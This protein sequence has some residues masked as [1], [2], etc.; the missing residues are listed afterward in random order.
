MNEIP[1]HQILLVTDLIEPRLPATPGKW[2]LIFSSPNPL[3]YKEIMKYK[4]RYRYTLPTWS[5]EEMHMVDPDEKNWLPLYEKCGGIIRL[6]LTDEADSIDDIEDALFHKGS[7]I[8]NYF[9]KYGFGDL[10]IET[11]SALIHM[12]PPYSV[13]KGGFLYRAPP[14]YSFASDYVFTQLA[15]N[16]DTALMAEVTGWFDAGGGKASTKLGGATAEYLFKKICLYLLPLAGEEVADNECT[17]LI[18][19]QLPL[20]AFQFPVDISPIPLDFKTIKNLKCNVFYRP[21]DPNMKSGDTF[22]VMELNG[23]WMLFVL[24]VTVAAAHGVRADSLVE[25][26]NSF[27]DTV[28]NDIKRK[29]VLFVTPCEGELCKK[30]LFL[31]TAGNAYKTGEPHEAIDFEQWVYRKTFNFKEK[32]S[33]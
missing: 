19:G 1:L 10:D 21:E 2:T 8:A 33:G 29:V 9:S 15:S 26:Y 4:P 18:E 25:I 30:Q 27:I 13:E 23:L 6:L 7:M 14:V 3:R 16:Y 17:S 12:N 28:R 11:N 31:D 24:Q 22:F 32:S 5:M 20:G